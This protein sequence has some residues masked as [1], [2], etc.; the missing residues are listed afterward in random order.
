MYVCI[1]VYSLVLSLPEEMEH[2]YLKSATEKISL[3]IHSSYSFSQKI[4][5][6]GAGGGARISQNTYSSS[7]S[8]TNP[9]ILD[10]LESLSIYSF[11]PTYCS[12]Y[13]AFELRTLDPKPSPS[14]PLP[15]NSTP[16]FPVPFF[17]IFPCGQ[18]LKSFP[19]LLSFTFTFTFSPRLFIVLFSTQPPFSFVLLK[20]SAI[21]Q[22][23]KGHS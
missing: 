4:N 3:G 16:L 22:N 5:R 21:A 1:Y 2:N 23:A 12:S 8:K 9:R 19:L 13:P 10:F 11:Y 14:H 7:L 20:F 6:G 17:F 15:F 18:L